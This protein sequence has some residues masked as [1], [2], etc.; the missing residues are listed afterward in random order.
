MKKIFLIIFLLFITG[1]NYIELNDIGI[2]TMMAIKYNNNNN[3]EIT[4]EMRENI[5]DDEEA[6]TIHKAKGISIEKTLQEL[7]LTANKTLYFIDINVLLID[8]NTLNTKMSNIVDY[9]TRNVNFGTKFNILIDNNIED[10]IKLMKEK[11]KNIGNYIKNIF[12]NKSNNLINIKYDNFLKDYLNINKDIILPLSEI[13]NNEYTINKAIIF[14]N[15]KITNTLKLE[16][17][18]I[19]NLLNNNSSEYYFDINYHN[20]NLIYRISTHTSKINYQEN[21]INIKLSLNGTF[22][23]IEDTNLMNDN[24]LN[25][26][27]LILKNKINKDISNL[28]NI[29]KINDSDILS[30]KKYYFNKERTKINTIKNLNYNINLDLK[31]NREGLIF[32]SI[33]ESNEKNR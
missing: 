25:E 29:L 23:E 6:S 28:I 12:N 30:F 31:L 16:N 32:N 14:Q 5:K 7:E 21:K 13:N 10:T 27:L 1:C 2:V 33:G 8:E 17:I 26:I 3:Y 24:N 18:Q 15:K 9:L 19:Y 20:K 22:I 11:H 4:I